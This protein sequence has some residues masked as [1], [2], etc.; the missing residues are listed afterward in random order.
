M[1]LP[2][3]GRSLYQA[4]A[5]DL[6]KGLAQIADFL[7][8]S[9]HRAAELIKRGDIPAAKWGKEYIG[10]KRHIARHIDQQTAGFV[11]N[12]DGAAA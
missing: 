7:G 2:H 8:E 6:L 9:E 3:D 12:G 4:I 5:D 1:R 11:G 10:S